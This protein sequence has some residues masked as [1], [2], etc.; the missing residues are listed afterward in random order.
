[1]SIRRVVVG[2]AVA[3][4]AAG[5]GV[6]LW[7]GVWSGGSPEPTKA[8]YLARVSQVCRGYTRQLARIGAPS[9]VTAYGDVV[10]AVTKV[11]PLL[12][13]Q[14]AAMRAV[15]APHALRPGLERLFQL[16][17]S[18]IAQLERTLGAARRRDAGGVANGLLRFS[19]IRNRSHTLAVAIGIRCERS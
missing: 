12:R 14:A 11:V 9:D 3:A 15:P 8:D 5:L 16:D 2:V 17:A 6:G 19:A 13:R 18:S 7:L 4:A 10:D 1:M